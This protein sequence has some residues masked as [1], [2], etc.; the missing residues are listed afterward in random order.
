MRKLALLLL[1]TGFVLAALAGAARAEVRTLDGSG[2]NRAHPTWGK[3]NTAYLRVA[4]ANYANRVG[5]PSR[6]RLP[7]TSATASSTTRPRTCSPKTA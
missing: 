4:A 7:A 1:T 6:A 2:N 3:S 5:E